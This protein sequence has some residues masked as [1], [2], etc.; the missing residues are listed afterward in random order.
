MVVVGCA[1]LVSDPAG[2]IWHTPLITASTRDIKDDAGDTRR[3][4][5]FHGVGE[6]H[7]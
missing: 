6:G 2:F 5:L 3:S 7:G 1:A 4:A